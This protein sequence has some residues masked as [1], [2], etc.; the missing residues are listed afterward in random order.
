MKLSIRTA[1]GLDE[2]RAWFTLT[3]ATVRVSREIGAYQ[4]ELEGPIIESLHAMVEQQTLDTIISLQGV[5]HDPDGK[6]SFAFRLDEDGPHVAANAD[7]AAIAAVTPQ[8]RDVVAL[9]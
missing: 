8:L 1:E 9:G 3:R 7:D 5:L 4:L 6:W 2:R